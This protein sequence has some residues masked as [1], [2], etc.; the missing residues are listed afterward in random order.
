MAL[1]IPPG[2]A[3]ASY[4]MSLDGDSEPIVVTCGHE[5]DSASGANVDDIAD[6][7]FGAFATT[8][9][10]EVANVY[11]LEYVAAYVGQD[12]ADSLVVISGVPA[13]QGGSAA[14]PLPQNCA[15]L[16][17]KRTDLAGRRGRGRLYLPG[18]PENQVDGAGN[19]ADAHRAGMQALFDDWYDA[20]TVAV[21]ARYYPPVVLH[22]SEGAGI[23]PAP[24]P[25]TTFV[26]EG[27][28]ATQRRRLRK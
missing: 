13:V 3:Q 18:L 25:I 4:V 21:G 10:P 9:L 1:I 2:F 8:V 28:I 5:L 15:L 20:L 22:R 27:K 6:D 19:V 12:A 11:T 16:V 26:V 7:L 24:T 17:R 14:L 23:E